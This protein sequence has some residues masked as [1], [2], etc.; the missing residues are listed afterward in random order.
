MKTIILIISTLILSN[1]VFS[2]GKKATGNIPD[3]ITTNITGSGIELSVEF[4]KGKKYSHPVI[5]IWVEDMNENYIQTVYVSY[6]IAKGIFE[7][8]KQ[9]QGKWA[10]GERRRPSA[11][12]YWGHKR[13]IIASDGLFT[14]DRHTEVADAYTGATPLNN[15]ILKTKTDNPL[16]GKFR[17]LLEINQ[18]FDFN[19]DWYNT[20]F[21]GDEE[22]M[23]SSQPSLIYSVTVDPE[24]KEE[25]YF[26]NPIGHG[27]YSGKD[28]KLYTDL[29]TMTTA[30]K[31]AGSIRVKLTN[32]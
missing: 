22:Y 20:K 15:F 32:K 31:I 8:G 5:A 16:N 27:H 18:P 25:E 1:I 17:I 4:T 30:M 9:D 24:K 6:S 29:S 26:M 23:R 11:L 2:Q 7:H 19:D 28:G 3:I 13:G 14:P 10:P 21:P 12:P